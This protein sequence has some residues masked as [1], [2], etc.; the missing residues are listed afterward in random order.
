M[1]ESKEAEMG[2]DDQDVNQKTLGPWQLS[3]C[4]ELTGSA[5]SQQLCGGQWCDQLVGGVGG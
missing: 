4:W 2:W 1:V 3:Q 5:C